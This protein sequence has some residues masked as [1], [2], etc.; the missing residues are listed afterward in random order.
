ML[1][2]VYLKYPFIYSGGLI[3]SAT[4]GFFFNVS[5]IPKMYMNDETSLDTTS[6][7]SK[8]RIVYHM[9]RLQTF[10]PYPKDN[11]YQAYSPAM[12][13]KVYRCCYF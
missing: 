12:I 2:I 7:L 9:I 4:E 5:F 6:H 8:G 1:P 10:S 11:E 13:Q 3:F